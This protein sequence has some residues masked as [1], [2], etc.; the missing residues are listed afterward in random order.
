LTLPRR[1]AIVSLSICFIFSYIT[2]D[3]KYYTQTPNSKTPLKQKPRLPK[4]PMPRI[5][6]CKTT[7]LRLWAAFPYNPRFKQALWALKGPA[8]LTECP[9]LERQ[10]RGLL[11]GQQRIGEIGS[12]L[13]PHPSSYHLLP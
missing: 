9:T 12:R 4:F 2:L 11:V 6:E 13:T 7:A 10:S 1:L 3:L 5:L 8:E